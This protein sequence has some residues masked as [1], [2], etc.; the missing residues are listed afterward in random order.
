MITEFPEDVRKSFNMDE[1]RFW[2][3]VA[4]AKWPK[5]NYDRVQYDYIKI[6]TPYEVYEFKE[7]VSILGERAGNMIALVMG[8]DSSSDLCKHIVGLG[9]EEYYRHMNNTEL[10]GER[11]ESCDYFECFTY[12]IPQAR[13]IIK[14]EKFYYKIEA[15]GA[16]KDVE[17]VFNRLSNEILLSDDFKNKK[18][19]LLDCLDMLID[20]KF[21]GFLQNINEVRQILKDIDGAFRGD[22]DG[23]RGDDEGD[24]DIPD[25][26]DTQPSIAAIN[27]SNHSRL[28][29]VKAL[30]NDL[31][32]LQDVVLKEV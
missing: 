32:T 15:C 1:D 21:A 14:R 13:D 18:K 12:C 5:R 3:L 29:M 7:L 26:D 4:I 17:A 20:D 11:W 10:I 28:W 9:R 16:K 19:F 23:D 22:G 31:E 30:C 6:L 24:V 8:S 27:F 2:E 25:F